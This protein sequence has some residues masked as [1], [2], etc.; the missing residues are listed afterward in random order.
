MIG[1]HSKKTKK[2]FNQIVQIFKAYENDCLILIV[3]QW[4]FTIS[5]EIDVLLINFILFARKKADELL[6]FYLLFSD[7]LNRMIKIKEIIDQNFRSILKIICGFL[8]VNIFPNHHLNLLI[9]TSILKI[10]LDC[11]KSL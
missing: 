6:F 3:H 4:G 7:D 8:L 11:S 9:H 2:K 5:N 1:I 10:I